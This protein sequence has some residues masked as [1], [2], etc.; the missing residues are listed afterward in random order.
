MMHPIP[1]I[2]ENKIA[3]PKL[4]S[5]VEPMKKPT[6]PTR[7]IS[8]KI[9]PLSESLK[10]SRQYRLNKKIRRSFNHQLIKDI[11]DVSYPDCCRKAKAKST[12]I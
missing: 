4:L 12:V 6:I 8:V 1:E 10:N 9:K 5:K 3:P 2:I 7:I 11:V